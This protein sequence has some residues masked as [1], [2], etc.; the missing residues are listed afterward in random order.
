MGGGYP[1]LPESQNFS[2]VSHFLG[3]GGPGPKGGKFTLFL[4]F[5]SE[6]FPICRFMIDW[7]FKTMFTSVK[8]V[9]FK[10]SF[11]TL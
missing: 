1:P 11:K 10:K 3:G 9:L 2:E 7:K 4:F 8:L 6:T 5:S